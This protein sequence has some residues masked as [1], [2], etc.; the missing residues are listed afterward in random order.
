MFS[1]ALLTI[2]RIF[3]SLVSSL[4]ALFNHHRYCFRW[5][6]AIPVKFFSASGLPAK[7]C[8]RSSGT[9]NCSSISS[10]RSQEPVSFAIS[11]ASNPAGVICPLAINFSTR[12]L[13]LADQ[14]LFSFLGVYLCMY[15]SSSTLLTFESIHP[16]QSAS[17][18]ASS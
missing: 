1:W 14:L 7:A 16:K 4:L 11:I 9:F 2:S 6:G 13:L 10:S 3:F 5:E 18:T 12:F 17:S 15:F 8:F